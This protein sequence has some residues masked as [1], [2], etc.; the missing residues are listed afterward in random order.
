MVDPMPAEVAMPQPRESAT[1]AGAE[2]AADRISS[3]EHP[4][5]R[6][7][8][9]LDRRSPF[10]IGAL[11][12]LG[13]ALSAGVVYLVIVAADMLVLVGLGFFVGVGLQPAVG[14]LARRG[15]PRPAA[16][17]TVA[18]GMLLLLAGFLLALVL[19]L[20]DGSGPLTRRVTAY[21]G[22]LS[23]PHSTLGQLNQ[24][25]H[26]VA[27]ARSL[28]GAHGG[29]ELAATVVRVTGS[30]LI[31]LVLSVY[32][33][34]DLPRIR[35]TLYRLVP[36]HRRPR[37]ILLGDEI[38]DK[39]AAYLL[40][41]ALI[42]LIAGGV[43]F[44]W[45]VVFGVPYA[46]LL[47]IMVAVLD[48]VPVVGSVIAGTVVALMGLTVSVPVCVATVGLFVAYKLIEDYLLLP[49]I[50]SRVVR[51]PAVVTVVAVL[52]GGALLGVVGA[53]VAIPVAAAALLVLREV[54]IP[55]LDEA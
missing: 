20:L 40:G 13:A 53:L 24:R 31:V 43:T 47:A 50:I 25:F 41:N 12:T 3:T 4:L 2:R 27:Q 5:G 42:S 8:R 38:F 54:I 18:V 19:P 36:A 35:R 44:V 14:W 15:L 22:D 26:L 11:A 17:T 16:V 6:P 52:I 51:V 29:T 7:G 33:L 32:F 30:V 46:P 34:A 45:L 39:V 10:Y 23:D 1:I 28:I 49:K 9:P 21:L 37:V 55:R 48:L